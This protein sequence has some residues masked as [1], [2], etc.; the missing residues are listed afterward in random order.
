MHAGGSGSGSSS[1]SGL[2]LTVSAAGLQRQ[3]LA[4]RRPEHILGGWLLAVAA[5][6]CSMRAST[7]QLGLRG[8]HM[9]NLLHAGTL[10]DRQESEWALACC[11]VAALQG[12]SVAQ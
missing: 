12:P 9:H 5:G 3:D 10:A 1:G 6:G 7:V 2:W 11:V 4:R 8:V